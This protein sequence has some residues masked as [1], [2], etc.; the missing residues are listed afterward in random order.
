MLSPQSAGHRRCWLPCFLYID[1]GG[2]TAHNPLLR[3]VLTLPGRQ[4]RTFG[5][6]PQMRNSGWF[7][8]AP[9]PR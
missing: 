1:L 6:A 2:L 8:C 9:K 5:W 3:L 4:F 7:S